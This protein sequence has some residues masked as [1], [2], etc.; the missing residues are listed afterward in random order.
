M[1]RSKLH[2]FLEYASSVARYPRFPEYL[3]TKRP[4]LLAIWGKNDPLFLP[5]GAEA[6]KRDN[7][8]A[9]VHFYDAGYFALETHAREIASRIREFLFRKAGRAGRRRV[10]G[11]WLLGTWA[12]NWSI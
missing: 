11:A 1:T 6:F 3:R 10:A 5:A 9:E 8:A 4:P 12:R 2:L 7:P